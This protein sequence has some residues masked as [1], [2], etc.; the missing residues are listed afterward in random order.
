MGLIARNK[1]GGF[2]PVPAGV[3]VGRC[4]EVIDLGTQTSD[5]A[6]GLK[7]AHKLRLTFEL[8]GEDDAG[9]PL[10]V[11]VDGRPMPMTIS[12]HYTVSLHEK[13]ALRRDLQS[14]RGREFTEAE[15]AAFDVAALLGVY[16]L[17]NVTHSMGKNGKTYANISGISA[18]PKPMQAQKPA[19]VH[20]VRRF[21][22]DEPDMELF[23]EL[24]EWLQEVIASAPEFKID[25]PAT[26]S[27]KTSA[28][29]DLDDL[30][31]IPF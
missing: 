20:K 22:L 24:P 19:G 14:W 2:L 30:D 27:A 10:T 13:A 18:L 4:F 31:D 5:G 1:G 28:G 29:S 8:F 16:A 26:T 6:F 12:K 23:N 21:D 9:K 15:A 17:I 25:K 11:N 7:A 3:H